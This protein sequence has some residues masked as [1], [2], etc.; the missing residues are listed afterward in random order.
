M[1]FP[2]YKD[3]GAYHYEWFQNNTFG[4]KDCVNACV[5]FCKGRTLDVGCGDGLVAKLI[6]GKG[7]SVVGIDNNKEGLMLAR[8]N[9]DQALFQEHNIAWPLDGVW[10][11]MA[12]LNVIE[13][14]E[15]P[16]DLL[17]T[18]KENI[19]KAGI[20]ITDKK[21]PTLGKY[22]VHEFTKK[23]LI[24][25]FKDYKPEYFEPAEGFIGVKIYK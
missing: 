25:L 7:Y 4:Y 14:L 20:I 18:F 21:Q 23:E 5:N 15:K 12:C 10:D 16:E 17:R 3:R 8:D 11:Y 13:H 1:S 19:R 24:D 9:N 22:H 2:K 6:A